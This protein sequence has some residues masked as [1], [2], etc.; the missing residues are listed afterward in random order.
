MSALHTPHVIRKP[1]V[2]HAAL[3][4]LHILYTRC[5]ERG[6]HAVSLGHSLSAGCIGRV[7]AMRPIGPD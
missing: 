7:A 2:C 1:T 4:V 5:H 6:S 3:H